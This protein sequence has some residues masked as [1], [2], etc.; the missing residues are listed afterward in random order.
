LT[1]NKANSSSL[2]VSFANPSVFGQLVTFTVTASAVAPGAGIPSGNVTFLDGANALATVSLNPAGIAFLATSALSVGTHPI[3]V[4]YAGDA[5]FN[6]NTSNQ[7]NQVVNKAATTTTL[8]S[9]VNPSSFGQSVTFTATVTASAPGAGTPTGTVTFTDG[10]TTLGTGTLAGGVATFATA[11]LSVGTHSIVGT[12]GGDSS[13]LGAS[14]APLSQTVTKAPTATVLTSS[15][16]PSV[17]GQPVALTA[18]VTSIGPPVNNPGGTTRTHVT[19]TVQTRT[20]PATRAVPEAF[21]I[22]IPSGTVTFFDGATQIGTATLNNAGVGTL[23]IAS[24]SVGTHTITAV[25]NGDSSFL[26][27]TSGT[28]NQ[29]VNKSNSNLSNVTS[30]ANPSVFG[31]TVTFST[32]ATAAAPGAGIPTGVVTFLDN[33]VVIGTGTLNGSGVA[34]FATNALAVGTHPITATYAGDGNFNPAA[35]SGT[36]TQTVNKAATTTTITSSTPLAVVGGTVTYTAT[37]S[38]VAPGAGLPTGT[39]QFRDNGVNIGNPVTLVNGVAQFTESGL[40]F[41]LHTITA[42][43][44][45]DGN[46]LASTGTLAGGQNVGLQFIDP[47]NGNKLIIDVVNSKYTFITGGG[48]TIVSNV[49]VALQF[50]TAGTRVLRFTSANPIVAEVLI[51]ETAPGTLQGKFYVPSTGQ[52]FVMNI[53]SGVKFTP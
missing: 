48:V 43:Y 41:G 11:N 47:V 46:F 1:V 34:T 42:V 30:N 9:S 38:P 44:S 27:S 24:L 31:Q 13:F 5:N 4:T 10:A 8:V 16:N 52:D 7:V 19:R 17:F 15:V 39:V 22:G 14:S 51:D 40:T 53:P 49:S 35:T 12:Y 18:T 28:V 36:L 20:T 23:T 21:G 33:G 32:T 37:V 50:A 25:Y 29:V 45:G 26:T 3:T 6:G 2:L